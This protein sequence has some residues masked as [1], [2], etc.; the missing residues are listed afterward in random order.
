MAYQWRIEA[1]VFR[2]S[3]TVAKAVTIYFSAIPACRPEASGTRPADKVHD[4]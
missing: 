3:L 4:T 1:Q 2:S